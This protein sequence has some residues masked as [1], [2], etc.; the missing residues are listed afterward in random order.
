VSDSPT[1]A[2]AL[3]Q[4]VFEAWSTGDPTSLSSLYADDAVYV[5][6]VAGTLVGRERIARYMTKAI[7]AGEY[8]FEVRRELGTAREALVEWTMTMA[9][10]GTSTS[11]S[12]VTAVEADAGRLTS[13]TD[14][15][16]SFGMR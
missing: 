10:Q 13:H 6:P 1:T 5:E 3:L 7:A 9:Q 11:V 12:G 4:R 8:S 14:Y 2:A 15:F 16:D